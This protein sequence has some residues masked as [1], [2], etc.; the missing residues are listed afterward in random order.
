MAAAHALEH[1]KLERVA[2][3]DFDVHHGNGTEDIFHDD[4]R[5]MLC[6]TFQHPF[7]PYTGTENVAS[8]MVNV[9]LPAGTRG[10]VV[11]TVVEEALEFGCPY[12]LYWQIYDNECAKN[13]PAIEECRG[14][15]LVKSH[16]AR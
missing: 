4:T 12:L 11:R 10:D 14:F 1:H 9:P 2:I 8:N 3:A 13:S 16:R 6:S 5:V 15:W 7:Y